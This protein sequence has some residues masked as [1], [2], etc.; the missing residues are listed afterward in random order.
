VLDVNEVMSS[1]NDKVSRARLRKRIKKAA[2]RQAAEHE[3][4]SLVQKQNG[5][6]VIKDNPPLIYHHQLVNLEHSR[7][8]IEQAFARY[9]EALPDDRKALLDHYR[10]VDLALKVVGIGSVG[11][12]CVIALMMAA[13]DDVLFLQVKE[14]GTSVLEP[15][16]GKSVY[17]NHGQRV[18]AGQRLM[19]S[20]SD[21]FLGWTHGKGGRHFYIRQLNDMKM[22]VLVDVF[23]PTTMLDYAKLC[24]WTLARAHAKSGDPDMIAGYLG[25]SDVFDRSV[26]RFS[27]LYAD[28][29][30][31]DHAAFMHAIREGRIEVQVEN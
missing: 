31:R 18:V 24:G 20:A 9:R 2:A 17:A 3:S 6:F 25:K 12:L 21:I 1:V 30:E 23:D 15:Y 22:K 27:E 16:V 8:N 5:Q 19:Q 7:D 14:A 26:T 13:D 28:Q 29:M 10:L 4:P 11:T